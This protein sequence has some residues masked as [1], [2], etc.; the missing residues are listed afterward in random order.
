M[1]FVAPACYLNETGKRHLEQAS[2]YLYYGEALY[3]IGLLL[4]VWIV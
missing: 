2:T 4:E 1:A 3:F